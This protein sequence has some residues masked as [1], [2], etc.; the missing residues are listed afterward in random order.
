MKIPKRLN[1]KGSE[2]RIGVVDRSKVQRGC[3]GTC[4]HEDK[5]IKLSNELTGDKL[6]QVFIHELMHA[7]QAEVGLLQ[8]QVSDDVFEILCESFASFLASKFEIRLK[9]KK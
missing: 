7:V 6:T 3:L 1:I 8:A 4:D 5:E 2:Y 9:S